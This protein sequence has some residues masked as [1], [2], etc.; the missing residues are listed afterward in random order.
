[1]PMYRK[2]VRLRCYCFPYLVVLFTMFQLDYYFGEYTMGSQNNEWSTSQG[3]R[4][5][6]KSTSALMTLAHLEIKRY[7]A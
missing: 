6:F 1:M 4:L 5:M 3:R 2:K 7:E